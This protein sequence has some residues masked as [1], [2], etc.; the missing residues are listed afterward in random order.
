MENQKERCPKCNSSQT[1][2]RSKTGDYHCQTCGH[3]FKE[4]DK[5]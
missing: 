4:G 2:N 3:N 5:E 1:Y